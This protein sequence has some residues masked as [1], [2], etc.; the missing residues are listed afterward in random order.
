MRIC[1]HCK[2][3]RQES[4]FPWKSRAK[5][6]R[7][8]NCSVCNRAYRLDYYQRN[9]ETEIARAMTRSARVYK[10][11]KKIISEAK[12]SGC[13]R[14]PESH[15][16]ALDFHHVGPKTF[17]IADTRSRGISVARLNKE[18]KNCILLCANCHRKEHYAPLAQ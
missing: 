18:L 6:L 15:P 1:S 16:A 14:C 11:T 8:T 10:V 13:S 2:E 17:S 5:G 3:E 9:R 7:S 4:E 12:L